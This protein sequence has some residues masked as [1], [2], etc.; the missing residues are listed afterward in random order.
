MELLQLKYLC[1]AA[2][3]EN[4]SRAAKY[5]NIPQSAISKTI[6]QLERELGVPLF[7]RKG[8]RVVLSDRGKKFCR[9]VQDALQRLQDATVHLR[10]EGDLRGEIRLLCEEHSAAVLRLLSDFGAENPEVTFSLYETPQEPGASDYDLRLSCDAALPDKLG[11]DPLREAEVLLAVPGNHRLSAWD[12]VP[13]HALQGEHL[14]SLP[15]GRPAT[16]LARE[17]LQRREIDLPTAVTVSDTAS[18]IACVAAGMGI[19]FLSDITPQRASDMGVRLL[20]LQE[21]RLTYPTCL[22]YRHSLSPVAEAF[23]Q[24]LLHQLSPHPAL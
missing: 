24:V 10:G 16:R 1:T 14:I 13:L 17:L 5:H 15:P 9:E 20:P 12:Q 21:A 7:L 6:A 3:L 8:N 11:A 2:R 22:S 18:A 23:R 4:F 19:A